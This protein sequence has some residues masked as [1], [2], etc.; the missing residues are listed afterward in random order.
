MTQGVHLIELH[1]NSIEYRKHGELDSSLVA[2]F[3][4]QVEKKKG[5]EVFCL[6]IFL[7]DVVECLLLFFFLCVCCCF[8]VLKEN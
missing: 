6:L 5:N 3:A 1:S 2:R 8:F 4:V 7:F